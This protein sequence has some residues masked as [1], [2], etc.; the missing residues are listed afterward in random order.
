MGLN[1]SVRPGRGRKNCS[2]YFGSGKEELKGGIL[3]I[4]KV[5]QTKE[6]CHPAL[7][8]GNA[9]SDHTSEES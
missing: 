4:L 5:E 1:P 3:H 6:E 9:A 8:T 7:S 2:H